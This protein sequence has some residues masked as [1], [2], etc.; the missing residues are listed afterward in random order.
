MKRIRRLVA[1]MLMGMLPAGGQAQEGA[2]P[3]GESS[4]AKPDAGGAPAWKADPEKRKALIESL[5]ALRR[6]P[7]KVEFH[8]AMCYKIARPPESVSYTCNICGA[9]TEHPWA[10][11]GQIVQGLP[12]LERSLSELPVRI[13]YDASPLCSTCGKG[14]TPGIEMTT[15]CGECGKA[16]RWTVSSPEEED[17]L[18]LLFLRH[19]ITSFDAGPGKWTDGPDPERVREIQ[20]YISSHL[21]CED[22][23]SALGLSDKPHG[24]K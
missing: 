1:A 2:L 15:E 9:A 21:F 5:R 18:R 23:R 22:C 14:R 20:K 13:T 8:S 7:E 24:G 17:R 11:V 12:Y 4:E 19:P 3:P 16:F 6:E 10:G